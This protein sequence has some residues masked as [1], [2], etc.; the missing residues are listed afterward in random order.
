MGLRAKRMPPQTLTPPHSFRV[1]PKKKLLWARVTLHKIPDNLINFDATDE[2][3]H[4]DSLKFSKKY[5]LDIAYPDG[6]TVRGS[7]ADAILEYG[8]LKV[9]IPIVSMGAVK[10]TKKK[11][12]RMVAS[13]PGKRKREEEVEKKQSKK[14][15]KPDVADEDEDDISG[16]EEAPELVEGTKSKPKP[17]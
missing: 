3:F 8:I 15:K 5:L 13:I 10:L 1:D 14:G 7:E 12:G 6:I 4:V 9:K 16:D 11:D 2:K 17:Q